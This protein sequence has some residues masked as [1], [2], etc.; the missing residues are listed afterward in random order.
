[1]K[2]P[3][4]GNACVVK[5]SGIAAD[6]GM[7]AP[8]QSTCPKIHEEG[9]AA[10]A[11]FLLPPLLVWASLAPMSWE[12]RCVSVRIMARMHFAAKLH[13]AYMRASD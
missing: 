4:L 8:P 5:R 9:M 11:N 3:L 10:R 2:W 1:M 6:T 12:F 13:S 7:A